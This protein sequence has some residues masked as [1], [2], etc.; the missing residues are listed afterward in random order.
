[1]HRIVARFSTRQGQWAGLLLL[2]LTLAVFAG[3]SLTMERNR[4]LALE[5]E[6]LKTLSRVVEQNMERQLGG[7]NAAIQSVLRDLSYFESAQTDPGALNLRLQALSDAL[8]GVRTMAVLTASGDV[9]ASNRTDLVGRN[10]ADREYVKLAVAQADASALYLAP[11]FKT[12]LNVYSVNLARVRLD[13]QGKV[14][15]IVSATLDPEFFEILLASVRHR[16]AG[17]TALAHSSGRLLLHHPPRPDLLGADLNRPGSFFS[18]HVASGQPVTFLEGQVATTGE[19]ALM[20][21]HTINLRSLNMTGHLVVSV[22]VKPSDILQGWHEVLTAS[23]LLWVGFFLASALGLWKFQ[24]ERARVLALV[25]EKD[26]LRQRAEEEIRQLAYHDALTQLPNR[27]LLMDRLAQLQSAS[28][29]HGRYSALFFMDLDGFKQLNDAHGH[30]QG[31]QLLIAVGQRLQACVREEDTVAR[32]GGDEF[33]VMLF[34]LSPDA[35][36]ARAQAETVAHKILEALAAPYQLTG[37]TYRCT[38]S[39]GIALFGPQNES[40]DDILKRA[41][42]AMYAA[43]AGGRN[44]FSFTDT[45]ARPSA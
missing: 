35:G 30:D 24:H 13:S 39:I 27:R 11:P 10:F 3:T 9:L 38:I 17:W 32:L 29:R 12:I 26:A 15:R 41:D 6:H 16:D 18:R 28:F 2:F 19:Q 25:Q 4:L 43:K 22:A 7:T 44:R 1:M 31:D 45:P 20:S 14:D 37:L 40:V 34:E 21:Q 42:N 5:G 8:P 36:T 33:V 23:V